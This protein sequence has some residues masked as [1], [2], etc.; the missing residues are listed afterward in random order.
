MAP[1]P[2][3]ISFASPDFWK[4]I[5][6]STIDKKVGYFRAPFTSGGFAH[7]VAMCDA[8]LLFERLKNYLKQQP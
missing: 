5:R 7:V 6:H 3:P 8:A 1:T 2:V 4:K